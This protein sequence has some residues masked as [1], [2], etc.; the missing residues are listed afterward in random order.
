MSQQQGRDGGGTYTSSSPHSSN[1]L[2]DSYKGTPDTR[3]S[4]FSPDEGSTKSI[5][6]AGSLSL[7]TRETASCKHMASSATLGGTGSFYRG[8]LHLNGDP[9][10]SSSESVA[11]GAQKLSP[12]ASSFFPV[13]SASAMRAS[14]SEPTPS[15][16][17]KQESS[18]QAY[19]SPSHQRNSERSASLIYLQPR[20]STDS[21]MS[22][23]LVLTGRYS[24]LST[25]D[26]EE[27]IMVRL[28]AYSTDFVAKI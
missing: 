23:C 10:V 17:G 19:S 28:T 15:S 25:V 11:K 16:K 12:T 20:T 13:T 2:A 1:G 26:V 8:S 22:R 27:Y 4:A 7:L 9:F 14:A 6:V 18:D 3:L 21:G 5:K 24:D